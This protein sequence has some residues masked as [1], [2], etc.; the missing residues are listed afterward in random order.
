MLS[1][2][3]CTIF[4]YGQTGTGKT[5]TMSGDMED[6]FGSYSDTAGIVPRCLYKLFHKLDSDG[7]E[8]SVKCSF[9][10][11]Y[12]EEL[13][14]LLSVDDSI[15]L[16]LFEDSTKKGIVIQGMEEGY[17]RSASEGVKL[18]Q[19]G[20][21]KR[22]VA[23]TKCNDLSSRS[24]TVFTI[25][26]FTKETA[27]DGEDMLRSGKLN[28]VDLAGSENIGRS[29]AENKR[30]REA[31]MINQSLLTLGRVINSLVDKS[32]HVPYR[33]SKLTRLLQD[34]LG[35][36]TKT[37]IIATVS[38][39]RINLEETMSTLDYAAGAK[40][41]QNKPQINHMITKKALI[42]EYVLEIERLKSDLRATRLKQGVYLTNEH[43]EELNIEHQNRRITI[44]E[45][46]RKLLLLENQ[47]RNAKEKLEMTIKSFGELQKDH[48]EQGKILEDTKQILSIAET[49][50]STAKRNLVEETVLRKAH[51]ETETEMD[52]VGQNLISTVGTTVSDIGGLH[53]KIRKKADLD[54]ENAMLWMKVQ[55]HVATVTTSVEGQ[56]TN[57]SADQ[58]RFMDFISTKMHEFVQSESQRLNQVYTNMENQLSCFDDIKSNHTTETRNATNEMNSVLE[59][60]KVLRDDVKIKVAEGMQGLSVAAERIAAEVVSELE[61]FGKE[62]R[63]SYSALGKDIKTAFDENNRH[64]SMQVKKSANLRDEV[65][66]AIKEA[67]AANETSEQSLDKML[68]EERERANMERQNLIAQMASLVN[69]SAIEQEKRL[70]SK[71]GIVQCEMKVARETLNTASDGI[72]SNISALTDAEEVYR[73]SM[74]QSRENIKKKMQSDC[75]VRHNL[76]FYI[77][78]TNVLQV[79][80]S[81][82]VS[83]QNTANSIHAQTVNVVDAQMADISVKLQSLDEFVTRACENNEKHF[84]ANVVSINALSD[85]VHKSSAESK[86][87]FET[88][89][90][91][92]TEV[93]A[94]FEEE[95]EKHKA[96]VQPVVLKQSGTLSGLR[97]YVNAHMFKE[98]MPTA[99]TPKKRV[100]DYPTAMPKTQ[101][102]DELLAGYRQ[103]PR[104]PLADKSVDNNVMPFI[105][106]LMPTETSLDDASSVECQE[107]IQVVPELKKSVV[108]SSHSEGPPLKRQTLE[109]I[110]NS[111]LAPPSRSYSAATPV[112]RENATSQ[113][114]TRSS[115]R[116][117][118]RSI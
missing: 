12:N 68:K 97:D 31:G 53:A 33:E 72:E 19:N 11:L 7:T 77:I 80:E 109:P 110:K 15:K 48:E 6:S 17:I 108:A 59:E 101:S 81:H 49:D 55:D 95:V 102:H 91:T 118:E 50:L 86:D 61:S 75:L 54:V 98:Y 46:E 116:L 106:P 87:V 23:A 117:V 92:A 78:N 4:A 41:I 105:Q 26:V 58:T 93:H 27:P 37:C 18:L 70:A 62:M 20:S 3:N 64:I 82:N 9:I 103:Q 52:L 10:E 83:I 65:E 100:Y 29:G 66:K 56:L 76:I 115:R 85:H 47:I 99:Q 57:F 74:N 88:M 69:N 67:M 35:G 107:N 113:L 44:E 1:G 40:N 112:G 13:R 28:L 89:K 16:K 21:H 63:N 73:S 90:Q 45:N 104:H 25:T 36:R 71:I 39:A 22:Q 60:I 8:Y 32:Q 94:E 79:A 24:H 38:P 111:R 114:S 43:F 51:Q 14:D 30:A 5:Y 2:Y 84:D 96:S 34:S 42:R